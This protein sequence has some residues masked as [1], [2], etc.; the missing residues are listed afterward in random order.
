MLFSSSVVS[1]MSPT[2]ERYT[3]TAIQWPPSVGAIQSADG[4]RSDPAGDRR[5]EASDPGGAQGSLAAAHP[6]P[7]AELLDV[8]VGRA[9]GGRRRTADRAR[10]PEGPGQRER[11]QVARGP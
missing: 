4:D 9:V 10:S 11:V 7:P 3:L 8:P 2:S 5:G 6:Q 1:P